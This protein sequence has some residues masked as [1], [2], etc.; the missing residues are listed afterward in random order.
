MV[1]GDFNIHVNNARNINGEDFRNLSIALGVEQKVRFA[2]HVKENI[3]DL[4]IT[5]IEND[6]D[7]IL[8][9]L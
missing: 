8:L 4:I 6:F 7:I 1:S 5:E 2:T 9:F 3:L